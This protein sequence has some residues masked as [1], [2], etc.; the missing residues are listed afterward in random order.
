[1]SVQA[2]L[3]GLVAPDPVIAANPVGSVVEAAAGPEGLAT[4]SYDR[5]RQYRYRLSR[6]WDPAGPRV[7]WVML[8]P[9]TATAFVLDPTVRRCVRYARAWGFGGLEVVNLFAYRATDPA[10][11]VA[12]DDPVGPHNDD[13]IRAAASAAELVMAGWGVHG[14]HL[15]RGEA[16]RAML[17]GVGV[18]LH[19]LRL[20]KGGHPGHPLYLPGTARPSPWL[21]RDFRDSV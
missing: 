16:V 15:G 18:E 6:V 8:N 9:S 4:A 20:T 1:M 7:A 10:G 11:M 19:H 2:T 12:A 14:R 13:A 3:P 5:D 21:D 17:A